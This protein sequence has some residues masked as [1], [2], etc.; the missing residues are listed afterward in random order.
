MKD[1]CLCF[2]ACAYV[3]LYAEKALLCAMKNIHQHAKFLHSSFSI[4]GVWRDLE[5]VLCVFVHKEEDGGWRFL[6]VCVWGGL[7]IFR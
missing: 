1:E 2:Y 7:K 4:E 3:C 6:S 5:G